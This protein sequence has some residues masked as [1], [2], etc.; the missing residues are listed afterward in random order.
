MA[1]AVV[2]AKVIFTNKVNQCCEKGQQEI[3]SKNGDLIDDSVDIPAFL[4]GP[5]R[6][7]T[8]QKSSKHTA[9]HPPNRALRVIDDSRTADL[10][11]DGYSTPINAHH[12]GWLRSKS[13]CN[14]ARFPPP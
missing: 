1:A 13:G 5:D 3:I 12:C 2:I 7:K 9:L 6:A 10:L 11:A 4:P 14:L 8:V